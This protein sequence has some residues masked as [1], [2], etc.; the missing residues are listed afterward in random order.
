MELMVT[1]AITGAL[2]ALATPY[3]AAY[4]LN[5]RLREGGN[6][7][8]SEALAAQSEAI[9]RNTVVRLA[10][11]GSS[12]QVIDMA[13]AGVALRERHMGQGVSSASPVNVD[14]RSTGALVGG[15]AL[16]VNVVSE[17][18]VCSTD[19]RC[20]ALKVEAGGGIKLCN[21]HAVASC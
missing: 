2:L 16:Q 21:N 4:G 13:N 18:A 19:V 15:A 17:A 3:F 1:L 20:P 6:A 5:S 14:F 12:V 10:V 8:L 9:R 11:S 7:L